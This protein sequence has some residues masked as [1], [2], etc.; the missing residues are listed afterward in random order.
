MTE[1]DVLGL[2]RVLL[3]ACWVCSGF[4]SPEGTLDAGGLVVALTSSVSAWNG[5][6]P[7]KV[8]HHLNFSRQSL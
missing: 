6:I 8:L 2:S 1:Y 5:L 4:S 3:H 7:F